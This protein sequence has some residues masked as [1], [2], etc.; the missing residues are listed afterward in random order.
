LTARFP[1]A[2]LDTDT[3]SLYGRA[4]P[5]VVAHATAYLR[6]YGIFTFSELTR[7][8][9]I[10]G[11][12]LSGANTRLA[13]FERLCCLSRVIPLSQQYSRHAADAWVDP[14]RRGRLI[15][16]VD[17]LIAVTALA[18]GLAVVTRNTGHFARVT[19]LQ[20]V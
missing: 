5:Q 16:K 13:A 11:F 18:H 6:T 1:E 2:L 10:R 19:G 12:Q 3:L 4:H 17:I 20:G 14:Y 7:Y 8:E 15:G 9:V